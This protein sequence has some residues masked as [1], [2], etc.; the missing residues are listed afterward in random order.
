MG[1]VNNVSM[2]GLFETG[3]IRFHRSLGRHP[4]DKGVRWLVAA[5]NIAYVNEAH[6]PDNVTIT[7]GI[8]RIGNTSWEIY[9]AA[10][11]NGECVATCDTVM[12][13]H[14][15]EGR[16]LIDAEVREMMQAH[17]AGRSEEHTSELQSLMRSSYAVFC[18]KK[19]KKNI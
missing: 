6:F 16:R 4:S 12:V 13:T 18:L 9:S 8:G 17:F 14:G 5:V 7:S 10:F 11:Q 3:R 2:S 19:K 1:H 15:P